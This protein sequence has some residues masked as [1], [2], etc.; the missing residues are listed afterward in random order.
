MDGSKGALAAVRGDHRP[1]RVS[2]LL[3]QQK[4]RGDKTRDLKFQTP[5]S[6]KERRAFRVA[7]GW[8]VA[9]QLAE[10]LRRHHT[11]VLDLFRALDVDG[12]GSV[13]R[14][15]LE[16]KLRA[17]GIKGTKAELDQLFTKLDQDRSG[18]ISFRELQLA[19]Y[20]AWDA[21]YA[22]EL[23]EEEE[24]EGD[25]IASLVQGTS[26]GANPAG[27]A[28][29]NGPAKAAMGS[30]SKPQL[31]Y[32]DVE[33]LR[34]ARG[35]TT[36]QQLAS[37]LR[38]SNVRDIEL[39]RCLHLDG[40][41]TVTKEELIT[42]LEVLKVP[43]APDDIDQ[44]FAMLDPD[45]SGGI[46]FRELQIA[47]SGIDAPIGAAQ[48]AVPPEASGDD[49]PSTRVEGGIAQPLLT[50]DAP[51]RRRQERAPL[52]PAVL[53][54]AEPDADDSPEDE[55]MDAA[56]LDA[57]LKQGFMEEELPVCVLRMLLAQAYPIAR[58][59]MPSRRL[60]LLAYD[61]THSRTHIR[62]CSLERLM[63]HYPF[64]PPMRMIATVDVYR[65][66]TGDLRT[67]IEYL[68]KEVEAIARKRN[69]ARNTPSS[70]FR[71][72]L[73][74]PPLSTGHPAAE[75][76]F[77]DG[78]RGMSSLAEGHRNLP[79]RPRSPERSSHPSANCSSASSPA[80]SSPRMP[81]PLGTLTH[82]P[83][84]ADDT[85]YLYVCGHDDSGSPILNYREGSQGMA[86]GSQSITGPRLSGSTLPHSRSRHFTSRA[87]QHS[88]QMARFAPG[89]APG[90]R[91][92]VDAREA[93]MR[94]R[95]GR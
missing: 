29:Q 93:S 61:S 74:E 83:R 15:E 32:N 95:T 55:A 23:A 60:L 21:E 81:V 87:D 66:L 24:K 35:W 69:A 91:A 17:M 36:A 53:D 11:R 31:T 28:S 88:Y 20:E 56:E 84:G 58:V 63:R 51:I 92:R 39:F 40:D 44:L 78:H 5:F 48:G 46:D 22:Q 76:F 1:H 27:P 45:E 72:W 7:S 34:I 94:E 42:A 6:E 90:S 70:G 12:D 25:D 64:D 77:A 67:P 65:K 71:R 9:K 47:M 37:L 2:Q 68:S 57:A 41:G 33:T 75:S 13:T 89:M 59:L 73:R 80:R 86:D 54:A 14:R 3:K 79:S 4:A 52:R 85:G 16:H 19:M 18:A 49:A 43:A 30:V 62:P 8:G 38:Q 82:R 10:H 26:Q 50:E